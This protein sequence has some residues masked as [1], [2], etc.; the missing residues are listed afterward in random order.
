LVLTDSTVSG[1][2]AALGGG[3][4]RNDNRLWS[5]FSTITDNSANRDLSRNFDPD[6]VG[7]GVANMLGGRVSMEDTILAGNRD[8]RD[9]GLPFPAGLVSPDCFSLSSTAIRKFVSER[10]NVVGVVNANCAVTDRDASVSGLPFDLVGSAAT[11]VDPGLAPL[12]DNGGL[13]R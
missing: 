10:D 8:G 12:A 13:T 11:P 5:S 6:A 4:I 7:G 2:L 9:S 1:N 3:G